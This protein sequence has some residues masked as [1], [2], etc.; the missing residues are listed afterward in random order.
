MTRRRLVRALACSLARLPAC[1]TALLLTADSCGLRRLV[2]DDTYD[3]V[4]S[5]CIGLINTAVF[6]IRR[7]RTIERRQPQKNCERG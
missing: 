2:E 1:L 3:T 6:C 5:T 7:L 4:P